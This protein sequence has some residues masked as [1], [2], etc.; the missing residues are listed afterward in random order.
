MSRKE[1]EL[2]FNLKVFITID[3][4]TVIINCF[5]VT[6]FK[7]SKQTYYYYLFLFIIQLILSQFIILNFSLGRL[8]THYI[9]WLRRLLTHY[10]T[11]GL[12][13]FAGNPLT[14]HMLQNS[15]I[16]VQSWAITDPVPF[17][18]YGL[19]WTNYFLNLASEASI[20]FSHPRINNVIVGVNN[21]LLTT[22][23]DIP[24]LSWFW[25]GRYCDAFKWHIWKR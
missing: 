24:L 13:I 10:I 23:K 16:V 8:L 12:C 5:I 19:I 6:L 25:L 7:F 4:I 9:I 22:G 1:R 18:L 20:T 21:I 11:C 2:Q 14:A 15:W 17:L 3:F